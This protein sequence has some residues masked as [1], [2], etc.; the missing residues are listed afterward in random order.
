MYYFPHYHS[1]YEWIMNIKHLEHLLAV[2]D[3]KSFSRAAESLFITQSALSRSIQALEEELGSRLFDRIGKRNE[4]T[5]LGQDVVVRARQI[6]QDASEL[7]RSVQLFQQGSGGEIRVGLGSGPGALLMTPLLHHIAE[8]HPEVRVSITR[9]TTELQLGQLRARQLEALVVD[10][11]RVIPAPDL[12]IEQVAELRACFICRAD[13]PLAMY[14]SVT[15][16]QVL[17]FP[18]AS[19]P[20]S[21]EVARIMVNHYGAQADPAQMTTLQC[22]DVGSLIDTVEHSKAVFLG[23]AAAARDGL[24]AGRLVELR[25][26]PKLE[27]TARYAYVTLVGRSEAPVM[28][29]FRQFVAERLQE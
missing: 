20:L 16:S 25:M 6:V 27:A 21:D 2:A 24:Q 22:E 12:L 8:H 23:V 17:A 15:I 29:L 14:P 28:T 13:H 3:T 4:L 5:P 19:T 18:V 11:R 9:G 1:L 10:A 7:Q 26:A